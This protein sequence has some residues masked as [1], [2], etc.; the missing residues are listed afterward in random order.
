MPPPAWFFTAVAFATGLGVFL[1]GPSMLAG[2]WPLVGF[3]PIAAGV[4]LNLAA[5]AAFRR[6]RTTT[7]P[8]GAPAALVV[9]GVYRFVRNP[10]YLGGALI[11]V[12][13]ALLLDAPNALV[14]AAG[15]ALL[16]SRAFIPPEEAR[17]AA[18]FGPAWRDYF[19]R[20]PRGISAAPGGRARA[21]PRGR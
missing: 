17:L 1:P 4:A 21:A 6:A 2:A 19:A 18:A 14:V 3:A 13:Y 5:V 10:M 9:D 8:D 11:L 15:Y 16:A 12:G 20:T 7:D